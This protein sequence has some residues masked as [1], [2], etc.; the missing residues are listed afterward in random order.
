[1]KRGGG[2]KQ[3]EFGTRRK[4]SATMRINYNVICAAN[5]TS[6]LSS[7]AVVGMMCDVTV[8]R[9][10][11]NACNH[12]ITNH[13]TA[14]CCRRLL[15][16]REQIN[17][18]TTGERLAGQSSRVLLSSTQLLFHHDSC[19]KPITH[20][21]SSTF[22]TVNVRLLACTCCGGLSHPTAYTPCS[23][24]RLEIKPD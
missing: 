3:G 2:Q 10:H 1:M 21:Q 6:R 18:R 9:V 8:C 20:V 16:S 14:G 7:L 12:H 15:L 5:G 22:P 4:K 23:D 11:C 13:T 17:Y 24:Q 19:D